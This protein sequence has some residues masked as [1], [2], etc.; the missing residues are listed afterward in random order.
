MVQGD[1]QLDSKKH[2]P[3]GLA[4]SNRRLAGHVRPK[5]RLR[6]AQSWNLLLDKNVVTENVVLI[7]TTYFYEQMKT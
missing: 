1:V 6:V 4:Y 2:H 5:H 3:L 7:K